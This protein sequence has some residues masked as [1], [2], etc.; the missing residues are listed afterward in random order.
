MS[1]AH[2]GTGRRPADR[3]RDVL[4][5]PRPILTL[6]V[7]L[8]RLVTCLQ[9][10]SHILRLMMPLLPL[11]LLISVKTATLKRCSSLVWPTPASAITI[12]LRRM[13][14]QWPVPMP[15]TGKGLGTPSLAANDV[16]EV[17]RI[18]DS[19]KPITSNPVF[20]LKMDSCGNVERFKIRFVARSYVQKE[21][22][23][24]KEVFAPV[25]NLESVSI[26]LALAA[27]YDLELDAMRITTAYLNGELKEDLY[28]L[29]PKGIRIPDGYKHSLY[30]LKQAGRTWNKTLD[31]ALIGLGF[32]RLDTESCLYIYVR[33]SSFATL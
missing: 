27:K 5:R 16:Y 7:K 2:H 26:L 8:S 28:L 32:C 29:L 13:Q 21:G 33:A 24:Y 11:S 15:Q 25:A 4:R 19:V 9:S 22:I 18:P 31:R 12:C 17:V 14:R 1:S 23:N 3:N 10:R 30:G 6:A 20:R